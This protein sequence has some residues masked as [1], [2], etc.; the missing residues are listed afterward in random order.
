ML[1][2]EADCGAK[3]TVSINSCGS[4]KSNVAYFGQFFEY[5]QILMEGEFCNIDI[6]ASEAVARVAFR[7][8]V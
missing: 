2:I 4:F 6:D 3:Q 1:D 5:T 7:D 8:T